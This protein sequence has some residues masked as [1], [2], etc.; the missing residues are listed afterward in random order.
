MSSNKEEIDEAIINYYKLKS[1]YEV[2][3]YEDYVKEIVTSKSSQKEKKRSFQKLPKPQCINCMRNVGTLFSITVDDKSVSRLYKA[4]CGD[5][6]KPCPLNIQIEMP[7]IEKYSDILSQY[8]LNTLKKEIIQAKNDLLFGYTKQDQAFKIFDDLSTKLKEETVTYDYFLE[9]YISLFD[10]IDAKR[11]LQTKQTQLG[12]VIQEYKD[13]MTEAKKQNDTQIVNNAVEFYINTIVPLLQEIQNIK[14]PFNKV[15]IINNEYR[16]I[17]KKNTVEQTYI[18]YEDPKLISFVTGVQN[19]KSK[20]T[21]ANA[22]AN[23]SENAMSTKSK[24]KKPKPILEL[25]SQTLGLSQN[26]EEEEN[27]ES[28]ANKEPVEGESGNEEETGNEEEENEEETGNEEE[29]NEEEE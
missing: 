4:Q 23:A 14:Y 29:E 1:N 10:S 17:Q 26:K 2:N 15:E 13:M 11:N 28:K 19:T 20:S 25:I 12:L 18:E 9:Q 16:L 27:Q 8:N 21:I 24:K 6:S 3:F 7:N 22:T 5:I